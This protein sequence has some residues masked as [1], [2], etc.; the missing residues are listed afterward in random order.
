MFM[1]DE[2]MA[3]PAMPADEGSAPADTEDEAAA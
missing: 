1:D 3:T 2:P